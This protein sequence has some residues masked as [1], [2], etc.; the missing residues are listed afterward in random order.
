MII[1]NDHPKLA[2]NIKEAKVALLVDEN[3]AAVIH[4]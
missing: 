1:N 2:Y 4:N 3:V